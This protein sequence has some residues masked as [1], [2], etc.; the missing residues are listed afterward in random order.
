MCSDWGI[1]AVGAIAAITGGVLSGA[2]SYLL[3][4]YNRPNLLID[5]I[6]SAA[7]RV[8]ADHPVNG[9]SESFVYIRARVQNKGR[10]IAKSCR[11]FLTALDEVRIGGTTTPTV[12]ADSKVLSWAGW[13]FAPIDVPAGVEFYVDL[14]KVSKHREGWDFSVEKLFADQQNLKHYKGTYR[15]SLMISGDNAEPT[16]CKVDVEYHGDWNNLRAAQ[17]PPAPSRKG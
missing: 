15:F 13:K 6:G 2:Y 14:M 5:Y 7:N 16:A 11:V 1:A 12:L 10:H 4:R 17:V 9:V 8:E 3:A